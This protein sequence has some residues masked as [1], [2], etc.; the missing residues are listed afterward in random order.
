MC[1]IAG[2]YDPACGV[3]IEVVRR[4][5]DAIVHRGPDDSG[6][7]VESRLAMGV[8]RLSI[9][10]V[11]GAQQPLYNEDR[12]LV[13]VFNG[14]IYNYRELRQDL[15]ERGHRF[16]TQGDGEVIL[17]LYEEKGYA[18]L[19]DLNGM[20]AFCLWDA[21]REEGILARDRLGIKPLYYW[22]MGGKLVF[23]S[24]I[25][26]L[27]EAVGA[28]ELD[29]AAIHAYLRFMYIPAPLTPFKGVRKLLPASYLRFS[30]NGLDVPKTY[31][32]PRTSD[33][34]EPVDRDQFLQLVDDAIELQLR[35]DVPVGIFLSGGIDSSFV[36]RLATR[37]M[38][39]RVLAFTVDY[40]GASESE[41]DNAARIA[42]LCGC[43]HC[44]VAVGTADVSRFLPRLLWQMDEPHGDSALVGTYA[45]SA[46]AA[47]EVKVVLNGTGGDELFG[48]YPWHYLPE[49]ALLRVLRAMPRPI[50][51]LV[52]AILR[53][54]GFAHLENLA[55]WCD[56]PLDLFLWRHF[57]FK[58]WETQ[59]F[60]LDGCEHPAPEQLLLAA[61][62]STHG[63]AVT[64]MLLADLMFYLTDDVL[65]VLDKMTMAA[66]LEGRVPLLDHRVVEL[67]F[68]IPGTAKVAAGRGKD[69]LRRWLRDLLPDVVLIRGKVG[70]GA[71]VDSWM[72]EG[73]FEL[74]HRILSTRPASR[75]SLFWGLRGHALRDRLRK[76]TP[77]RVFLLLCL[78]VWARVALD[79]MD[80][81]IDLATM[82]AA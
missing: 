34:G 82:A 60:F 11:A 29:L 52:P 61:L 44:I 1:G 20:F 17:H 15:L 62:E 39:Q 6:V 75:D 28:A 63:D 69:L 8:R 5:C 55:E 72:R 54:V 27:R 22:T 30:V 26:A 40:V 18:L 25:K 68:R 53:R 46:T 31:W 45:V 43:D 57:Q 13:L 67:A 37:K 24:E 73:L 58:P 49:P 9:I 71:P 41:T 2:L 59:G 42:E 14:E 12:T 48:G 78:E 33:R 66:S 3:S 77:Q 4:M 21:A 50:R 38:G 10:D 65:L 36:T 56:G 64:R 80:P 74:T 32:H 16:R 51:S 76:L 79:G 7:H 81:R 23:A 70:F 47:R 19:D 35:S